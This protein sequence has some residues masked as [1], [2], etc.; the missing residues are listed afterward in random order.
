[1]FNKPRLLTP[2]PTALP[3]SVRLAMAVDMIHHRKP[4]FKR[5]LGETQE[6]L[7]RLFGT[8][9]VVLP[10][11]SSGTGA[12]SAALSALFRP[13]DKVL[14][15]EGGNFARR[16][17]ELARFQGLEPLIHPIR[18]GEAAD[19]ADVARILKEVPEIK[20]VCVQLCETSTGVQHPVRALAALTSASPAL[21][22]VDGVSG[23]GISPCP[24][25]EWGIDCLLTG[26]QK[27]LMLPPGLSFIALSARAWQKAEKNG[28][29]DFY[30]NLPEEKA[31]ILERQ[32]HFTPPVSLLL[33]LN[34]SL[35]LFFESG[36]ENIY[37]KQWALCSMAR[38]GVTAMG[39]ELFAPAAPAWGVTSVL[40]PAGVS[41]SAVLDDIFKSCNLVMASGQGEYKDKLVRIGHM[42]WV[43]WGDLAVGLHALFRACRGRGAA[44]REGDYLEQALAAYWQALD[45]GYPE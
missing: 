8:Q 45:S 38:R 43:D 13:G 15:P 25:D 30:F 21:L 2:G 24:M 16:W 31:R 1:M 3:E 42:G 44:L 33:G 17:V 18:P 27:G 22:V 35:D 36:L 23:V 28:P 41:S 26:S 40:M 39:L 19:P 20:G 7:R 14:V 37:R 5:I 9:E 34:K 32:T 10:L 6:K 29:G 12:M 11:A 4:E